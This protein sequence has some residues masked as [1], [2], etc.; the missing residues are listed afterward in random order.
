VG[1][2]RAGGGTGRAATAGSGGG[3]RWQA[4]AGGSGSGVARLGKASRKEVKR[5]ASSGAMRGGQERQGGLGW[6]GVARRPAA[7][8]LHSR[9]RTEEEERGGRQG[10]SCELQKLQG[11]HCNTKFSTILKLKLENDQNKSCRT[12]QTLQL[13]FRVEIQKL[14]G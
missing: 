8:L 11:S 5:W 9:G 6:R 13:L 4:A 3:L 1:A 10:L 12:F 14:K 7:A 2:A